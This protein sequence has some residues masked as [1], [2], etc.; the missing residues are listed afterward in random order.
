VLLRH[1]DIVQII[2]HGRRARPFRLAECGTGLL[3]AQTMDINYI[4]FLTGQGGDAKVML[5][6][7]AG[8]AARGHRVRA[9]VP[10]VP[11]SQRFADWCRT[12]G[13]QAERSPLIRADAQGSRQNPL[14]VVKFFL[15]QRGNGLL[16]V[17]AGDA[18]P[19]RLA[20]AAMR[21][22][23]YPRIFV[24]VH[25]PYE[26]LATDQTRARHWSH[27]VAGQCHIVFT[28]SERSRRVQIGSGVDAARV[29]AIHNG[30]DIA[31]FR[32]GDP[33]RAWRALDVEPGTPLVLF[34]SRL[35]PQKR[36]GDALEAFHRI[37]A[38]NPSA[39]LVYV[40]GG[41]LKADLQRRA[42][43]MGL[44]T[45]VRFVGYQDN[46]PDWLAAAAVWVLP[47]ETENFSVA[48]L[49]AMAA[50]CAVLSSRYP[51]SEEIIVDG[52]NA[53]TVPVGDVQALA[54]GMERLLTDADLCAHLSAG[55]GRCIPRF[56]IDRMVDRYA[57]AYRLKYPGL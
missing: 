13:V 21:L 6:L 24:T 12:R 15:A 33:G 8:M 23:R 2:S 31:R 45:R 28:P 37:A 57:E 47:S 30:V 40:G 43:G 16:H 42:A 29:Q 11:E 55:A 17:H 4:G 10:A 3:S 44:G 14:H 38:Q 56:S 52:E 20:M 48:V 41:R 50:G 49:E 39:L 25:S 32:S 9:V 27:A 7:A 54:Q 22:L 18:C 1:C 34:S 51:G 36:P 19:P 46:I 35:D 53:L 26:V 5:D